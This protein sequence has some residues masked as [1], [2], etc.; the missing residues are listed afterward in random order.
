LKD[1]A[2]Q[3]HARV[4]LTSQD[5]RRPLRLM[6]AADLPE[7]SIISF[8]ELNPSIPLDIVGELNRGPETLPHEAQAEY[9][10]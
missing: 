4:I 1:Q 7:I 10:Q 3:S 6:V 2:Q 9:A 8:N 5:L